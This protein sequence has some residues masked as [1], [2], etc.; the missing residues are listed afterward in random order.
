MI[1]RNGDRGPTQP[2]HTRMAPSRAPG[3]AQ[4]VP[5]RARPA[6]CL[7]ARAGDQRGLTTSTTMHGRRL[8]LLCPCSGSPAASGCFSPTATDSKS[9]PAASIPAGHADAPAAILIGR[10]PA[11]YAPGASAVSRRPLPV[12]STPDRPLPLPAEQDRHHAGRPPGR[13][14]AVAVIEEQRHWGSSEGECGPPPPS[15]SGHCDEP[16]KGRTS[17]W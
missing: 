15:V 14:Q 5:P 8:H 3:C 17:H 1:S 9:P 4:L 16:G 13:R 10:R 6:P 7:R 12:P 11:R 2:L